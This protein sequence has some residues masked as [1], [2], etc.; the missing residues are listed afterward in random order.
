M[1]VKASAQPIVLS[2]PLRNYDG[3]LPLKLNYSWA[4]YLAKYYV[5]KSYLSL[6]DTV[7]Y[8]LIKEEIFQITFSSD[9]TCPDLKHTV[10]SRSL[11]FGFDGYE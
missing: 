5:F 10:N 8:Y 4:M 11:E 1:Q 3:Q 2:L 6:V 9:L 7:L